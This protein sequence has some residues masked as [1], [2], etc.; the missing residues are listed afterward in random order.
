M[1]TK[2][3]VRA[4]VKAPRKVPVTSRAKKP[5]AART[6]AKPA[7][8]P[9]QISQTR[10]QTITRKIRAKRSPLRRL[11]MHPT[12][13]FVSLVIGV[14]LCGLSL[15]AVADTILTVT[16]TVNTDPITVAATLDSPHNGDNFTTS[17]QTVSGTCPA[18]S[19]VSLTRN[20]VFAGVAMCV[21]SAYQIQT[22]L[23]S[24]DNT[25]QVQDY[26]SVDQ[27]GPTTPP[28]TVTYT[29]PAN[30]PESGDQPIGSHTTHTTTTG[31][32]SGGVQAL[33]ITSNYHYQ[34]FTVD[35]KAS[36]TLQITGGKVPYTVH[37]DW[38]DDQTSD[39]TV[40]DQQAFTIDHVYS[41]VGHY[42][43]LINGSDADGRIATLQLA[44]M[45]TNPGATGSINSIINPPTSTTDGSS[46]SFW[47]NYRWLLLAWPMY[48]LVIL[49]LLAFWLGERRQY[50]HMARPRPRP[51]HA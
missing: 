14:L 19:Y 25:L 28:I 5:V 41:K 44:A 18:D 33:T 26:N 4:S 3:P 38:G 11:F 39:Q 1:K 8:S 49:M 15:R 35:E 16:G 30:A 36:W 47:Q 23:V 37:I 42:P 12:A 48:L 43:I 24:G 45:I 31:S 46:G 17:L 40:P 20:G 22:N 27:P 34:V 7:L 32:S 13:L 10:H 50:L 21:S 51:H 2:K 29:P 9:K 6:K